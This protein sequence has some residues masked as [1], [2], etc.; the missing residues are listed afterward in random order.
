MANEEKLVIE[1]MLT[2]PS[3]VAPMLFVG[4]GGCGCKMVARIAEHLRRRS[5]F[6]ERYQ[7]LIKFALVDTNVNDLEK[8]REL[9]DDSFLISDF[10]KEQY[11]NLA[12]GKMFLEPDTYFT[13]WVPPSYRFRA[14]D[15]AGAGQIRIEARLGVYYQMK[16]KD[17]LPRF[18][19][20]LDKLKSH[21]HGHRRLDNQDIRIVICYSVAGGT[22]SGSHLPIAY[23]LRDLGRQVGK[24]S[25]IGVAV[26]PSVFE[27]KTGINKDGTFA[28]GYAA[29]KETE[30]LMR[31]G[32]PESGFFPENG[33]PFHYD[34]SDES[35][36]AVREKP[37]DFLYIIDKPETFTVSD[38]VMAAADGLYL[39]FFSP[40]YGVQAG[41]YDN[42]TQHQRFL[43][44]HDFEGKGIQGFTTFY[45]TFGAAVLHVPVDGL[46]EYCAH[47]TALNLMKANFLGTVPGAQVYE[48]LRT[49]PD[50]FNEVALRDGD[51]AVPEDEFEKKEKGHRAQLKDALFAKR[52]RLLAAC[53]FTDGQED[54]K[55]LTFFRHGHRAGAIPKVDGA[56]DIEPKR[57]GNDRVQLAERSWGFSIGGMVLPVLAGETSGAEPGLL[58]AAFAR[59]DEASGADR[60]AGGERKRVEWRA[61]IQS[62]EEDLVRAGRNILNGG[63]KV[64]SLQYPGFSQLLELGFMKDDAGDIGLVAQRYAALSILKDIKWDQRAPEMPE[65]YQLGNGKPD[66][67][68]KEKELQSFLNNL[69]GQA[70]E[71]AK[72]KIRRE[73]L[74]KLGDFKQKLDEFVK[75]LRVMEEGYPHIERERSRRR[76]ELRTKGDL[77]TNRYI[78]DS[79]AF[80]IE[81]NRRMWDFFFYDRIA[82]L[83]ELDASDK[84]VMNMLAGTVTDITNSGGKGDSATLEKIYTSL[85][86]HAQGI[87]GKVIGGDPRSTDI[88]RRKGLMLPEA[89]ELEFDYWELYRS[90]MEA[91][92]AKGEQEVRHLI[93]KYRAQE[94]QKQ[95]AR[96]DAEEDRA[97][98]LRR[99]DYLRDKVLRLVR[100]RADLL[101]VYDES[102]DL[103]GGVRPD[104]VFHAAVSET[105]LDEMMKKILI[106][107]EIPEKCWVK[108]GWHSVHEIIVYRAA[109]NI[110]LY[111]FGRMSEMKNCY[112]AFRNLAKRPKVLHIDR[113]WEDS[114]PDLDPDSSQENHR[115]SIIREQIVNFATLLTTRH[116]LSK[117]AHADGL[118]C[119]F[120]RNG[121][122]LLAHP[123]VNP[124]RNPGQ[125]NDE[126][127]TV[128]LGESMGKAIQRLPEVLESDVVGYYLYQQLL[129]GVR[130]GL[131]PLVLAKIAELPRQWRTNHDELRNQYGHTLDLWQAAQLKDY[132]DAFHRLREAMEQ[133]LERLRN[134]EIEMRTIGEDASANASQ[135]S[136][137]TA[138]ANLRQCIDILTNFSAG[139]RAMENPEESSSVPKSFV[140]LFKPM[141]DHELRER[142]EQFRSGNDTVVAAAVQLAPKPATPEQ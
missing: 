139:W 34:P 28:N 9:A 83:P 89:L 141:K 90:N 29:L 105:I 85:Y 33:L 121:R 114:L 48:P 24:P 118:G 77:S 57:T 41:D 116:P 8:Y 73:F 51:R 61:Q 60:P 46:V 55:H 20:L 19:A 64:G 81:S 125:E 84:A 95:S 63:Y 92:D 99:D 126:K 130:E 52:L 35:K 7:G 112:H 5:D 18:R 37:F 67:V 68:V 32:A 97:R 108:E 93:N 111:V 120:R 103:Q 91:I 100:E 54:G 50:P 42:Y 124:D 69:I 98:T 66:D 122:Y 133:I 44:P 74:A 13:Q 38:P 119:I 17:F 80:Q 82:S 142:L 11:A 58:Q 128:F 14:G 23:M 76:E 123:E 2:K 49:N 102:R 127:G 107:S 137:E 16:H 75:N 131:A 4:L 15:T 31:L 134:R 70:E 59:I 43:V 101:C 106:R 138:E 88:A 136:K 96:K 40:L 140:D 129:H 135:L 132:S 115:Q 53:E 86:T 30:H 10:E 65:D 21:E 62:M 117:G 71:R 1:E 12:T 72:T 27:D 87:I 47:A 94:R 79:E 3:S 6:K 56:F 22:G 25:L 110:P 109:M 113:N 39:Q 78:L 45:G 104:R 26:L 36:R